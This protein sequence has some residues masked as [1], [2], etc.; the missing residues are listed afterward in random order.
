MNR[1]SLLIVV[2]FTCLFSFGQKENKKDEMFSIEKYKESVILS[3][4]RLDS[5]MSN[6]KE[7]RNIM[8]N[9][10]KTRLVTSKSE[11]DYSPYNY[12]KLPDSVFNTLTSKEKFVYAFKY[13]ERFLQNC[14]GYFSEKLDAP[15]LHPS[16]PYQMDGL[17]LSPRQNKS[18]EESRNA[19]LPY[20]NEV[21]KISENIGND[22]KRVIVNLKAFECLPALMHKYDTS[23][24]KDNYILTIGLLLMKN[25][26]YLD[27]LDSDIYKLVYP[28]EIH[29]VKIDLTKE[30]RKTAIDLINKYYKWKTSK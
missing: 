8:S 6:L 28:E 12:I 10:K 1:I 20:F 13:P 17:I 15:F 5:I 25:D 27:F 7:N 3:S 2:V 30:I 11:T 29:W 21:I 9:L 22:Y 19:I 4:P 16:L 14:S 18:L 23:R 24:I 26:K